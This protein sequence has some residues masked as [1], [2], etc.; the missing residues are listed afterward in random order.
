MFFRQERFRDHRHVPQTNGAGESGGSTGSESDSDGNLIPLSTVEK[1][2]EYARKNSSLKWYDYLFFRVMERFKGVN[3]ISIE[4]G[5]MDDLLKK[6]EY[7]DIQ[8]FVQEAKQKDIDQARKNAE[9]AARNKKY[10][11][12]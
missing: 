3:D 9:Q 6:N 2:I 11:G 4:A 1:A 7:L 8:D 10:K 5:D 12:G